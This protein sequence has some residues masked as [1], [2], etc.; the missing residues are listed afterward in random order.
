MFNLIS[1]TNF[2]LCINRKCSNLTIK[3]LK[4]FILIITIQLSLYS[5]NIL[6]IPFRINN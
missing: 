4:L 1:D 5:R 2:N 3:I 6:N